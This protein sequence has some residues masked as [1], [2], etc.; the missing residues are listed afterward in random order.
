VFAGTS[1][2]TFLTRFGVRLN[3]DLTKPEKA[4]NPTPLNLDFLDDRM[5]THIGIF[6]DTSLCDLH[7]K[8]RNGRN[9]QSSRYF[10]KPP[11][12]NLGNR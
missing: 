12:E 11:A 10:G 6:L 8:K 5:K 7:C 1:A 9:N 2:G 4:V 3:F